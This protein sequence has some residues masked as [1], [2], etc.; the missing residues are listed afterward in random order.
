MRTLL[1]TVVLCVLVSALGMSAPTQSQA[2]Y[3]N[4]TINV[5]VPYL[6]GGFIEI[7]TRPFV[8]AMSR[9]LGVPMTVNPMPGAAGVI[10]ITKV[11]QSKPDGYTLM[12]ASDLSFSYHP[13]LRKVRYTQADANPIYGIFKAV[14]VFATGKK[15]T[16]FSTFE[17]FVAYAQANPGQ[18]TVGVSGMNS[19][20]LVMLTLMERDLGIDVQPV[21]FDGAVAITNAVT[22]GHID[23]GFTEHT[24]NSELQPLIAYM[25]KNDYFPGLRDFADIGHPN[26]AQQY[27]VVLYGQPKLPEDI[28]LKLE[29]A[30]IKASQDPIFLEVLKKMANLPAPADKATIL[31]EIDDAAILVKAMIADGVL[32]PEE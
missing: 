25:G 16:K 7:I 24:Q 31:K 32:V 23:C 6:P 29:A 10:G 28:R 20:Y 11:L 14:G 3:P 22:S 26:L 18:V 4:R 19:I 12:A 5:V 27:K 13:Y 8:D 21:P 1:K 2:A 30:A 9:E 17:E 15:N